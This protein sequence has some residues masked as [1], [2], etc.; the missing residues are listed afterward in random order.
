VIDRS[1]L[2][3]HGVG[4][5]IR[6]GFPV[7]SNSRSCWV[8][9]RCARFS[10]Y[11]SGGGRVARGQGALD[12]RFGQHGGGDYGGGGQIDVSLGGGTTREISSRRTGAREN[13]YWPFVA[14]EGFTLAALH[15]DAASDPTPAA[16]GGWTPECPESDQHIS[17][18]SR[19]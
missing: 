4:A 5:G 12:G 15:S 17:I 3:A 7:R 14:G 19:G 6:V 11:D 2:N 8:L 1:H 10:P 13:D 16:R 18:G 9:S